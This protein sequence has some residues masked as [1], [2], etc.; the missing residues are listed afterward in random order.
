MPYTSQIEAEISGAKDLLDDARENIRVIHS[1]HFDCQAEL[2]AIDA[3]ILAVGKISLGGDGKRTPTVIT[4]PTAQTGAVKNNYSHNYNYVYKR[5]PLCKAA[6]DLGTTAD[7]VVN[8]P[9]TPTKTVEAPEI[10]ATAAQFAECSL[11]IGGGS[12]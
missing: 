12:L 3:A 8:L 2:D 5:K 6:A 11:N 9:E 10:D 1:S 7:N 4:A